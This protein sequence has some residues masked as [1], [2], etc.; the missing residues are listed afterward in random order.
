MDL[1][2]LLDAHSVLLAIR[3]RNIHHLLAVWAS[4]SPVSGGIKTAEPVKTV[5]VA[6]CV[7]VCACMCICICVCVLVLLC[8]FICVSLGMLVRV[9]VCVC[10]PQQRIL[11]L[12]G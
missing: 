8:V 9:C 3:H 10:L 2:T 6:V 4:N 5:C 7:T 12:A 11:V 1:A